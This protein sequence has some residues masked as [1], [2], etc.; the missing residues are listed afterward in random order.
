M[1]VPDWIT[2]MMSAL[3][4]G[5]VAEFCSYLAEDCT[6]IY[7]N[8]PPV[9]GRPAIEDFVAGFVG[10][11]EG[12]GHRIDEVYTT[13]RRVVFRGEVTYHPTRERDLQ[14]PYA[15]V[16]EIENGAIDTYQIYVD[17]SEL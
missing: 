8:H 9:E 16:L 5:D 14:V 6:F 13:P 17:S 3:D 7:A 12:L 15:N 10:S 2:E 11:L 1:H 4:D